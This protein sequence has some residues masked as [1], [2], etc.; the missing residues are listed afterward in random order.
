[1]SAVNDAADEKDNIQPE[2]PSLHLLYSALTTQRQSYPKHIILRIQPL[3]SVLI[4]PHDMGT[5]VNFKTVVSSLQ[6]SI[7][8][9][10]L[11]NVADCLYGLLL[12]EDIPPS[13]PIQGAMLQLLQF[14][15][16]LM[17]NSI[18]R[19]GGTI[20]SGVFVMHCSRHPF[21]NIWCQSLFCIILSPLTFHGGNLQFLVHQQRCWDCFTIPCERPN[22][23]DPNNLC[24][25]ASL[26]CLHKRKNCLQ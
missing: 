5:D 11:D 24:S 18:C 3:P 15:A 25:W 2:Y 10:I 26:R 22:T 20:F 19:S 12:K 13:S 8:P 17:P 1:M 21:F 4:K 6:A 9:P 7:I 16:L 23:A 14:C